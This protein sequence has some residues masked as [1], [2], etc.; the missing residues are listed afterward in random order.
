MPC[1]WQKKG[2]TT[3]LPAVRGND[4]NSFTVLG[5]LNI[6]KQ[7]FDGDLLYSDS[8]NT[9]YVVHFLDRFS[10]KVKE[11]G[12]KTVLILDNASLHT[13]NLV[14]QK[15][16]IWRERG[17]FLQYITAYSL[18]L[19]LIEILWKQMKYFWL[20]PKDYLS[21]ETLEN[22]IIHI[23]SQYGEKYVVNFA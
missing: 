6:D 15:A 11:K 1:A 12:R 21:I 23:L 9:A 16:S 22:A 10:L 5:L 7:T 8:A 3:L 4:K 19:N 20:K 17:L 13:A 18:E 14:K 2:A